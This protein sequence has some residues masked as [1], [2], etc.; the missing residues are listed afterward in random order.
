MKILAPLAGLSAGA[1]VVLGTALPAQATTTAHLRSDS[2][3]NNSQWHQHSNFRIQGKVWTTDYF[4]NHHVVLTA[5]FKNTGRHAVYAKLW[6]REGASRVRLVQPGDIVRLS[7]YTDLRWTP[8]ERG[9]VKVWQFYRGHQSSANFWVWFPALRH[10]HGDWQQQGSWDGDQ[11]RDWSQ[12]QGSWDGDQ[13]HQWSQT[14]A[15]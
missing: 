14:G 3:Q 7:V 6:T 11:N 13:N 15:L 4:R 5:W 10:H 1:L 12:Q 9:V 2:S 8:G